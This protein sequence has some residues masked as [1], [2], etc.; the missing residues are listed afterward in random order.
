MLVVS[1]MYFLRETACACVLMVRSVSVA[2]STV[3]AVRRRRPN[4]RFSDRRGDNV[5][6]PE[7][8]R[9]TKVIAAMAVVV[10][11]AGLAVLFGPI[12]IFIGAAVAFVAGALVVAGTS[13]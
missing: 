1:A 4:S 3:I 2:A 12:G 11:A 9:G 5:K 7:F 6:R 13:G 8:S 10:F